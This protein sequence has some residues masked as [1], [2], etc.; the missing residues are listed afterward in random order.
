LAAAYLDAG[1]ANNPAGI[2]K[3]MSDSAEETNN[4]LRRAG[5]Y[6]D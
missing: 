4:I 5:L 3:V 1:L 2:A 6:A